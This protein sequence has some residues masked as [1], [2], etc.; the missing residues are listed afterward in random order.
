MKQNR[1]LKIAI[2]RDRYQTNF[3]TPKASRHIIKPVWFLP[4]NKLSPRI[5]GLTLTLALP[6]S[7]DLGHFHNRIPIVGSMPF[8]MSFESHLPRYFGGENTALFKFLR[9]RL[10]GPQCRRI[11]AMSQCAKRLFLQQHADAPEYEQLTSKL[12]V[13]YPNMIMPA[14]RCGPKAS[15]LPLRLVFVGAGFGR[16]GGAVAV[17]AAEI[18]RTRR[19]PMHFH[20]ISSLEAGAGGWSDPQQEEFFAPYFRLID[21]ENVTFNRRLANVQVLEILRDSDFSILATFSDSFGFSAMESLAVGTPVIATPQGALP[22]FVRHRENGLMLP[23]DLDPAG[24]WV[25]IG[26]ADK[27]SPAY[28]NMFRG[29]IERMAQNMIEA[30]SPYCDAP[31]NLLPLRVNARRTAETLFDSTTRSPYLDDLYDRCLN[32]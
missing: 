4:T 24:V 21:A 10:A 14:Y 13:I 16:K 11:V 18:A 27:S 19:L 31:E 32:S 7:A 23:L 12:E 15:P 3:N 8:L 28:A 25:H 9:R 17:R 22:E 20:I 5:E 29:E 30:I 2:W 1:R 26:R 6:A